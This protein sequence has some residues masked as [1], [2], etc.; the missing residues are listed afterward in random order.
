M[1]NPHLGQVAVDIDGKEYKL[2]F[3]S[4][5]LCELEDALDLNVVQISELLG[6]PKKSR[7]KNVRAMF[8]ASLLDH[9]PGTTM[10]DAKALMSKIKGNELVEM[11]GQAFMLAFPQKVE[12]DPAPADAASPPKPVEP[13]ADGTGSAS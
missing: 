5:A 8:W 3:S 10:D 2:S 12:G 1:A 6:D 4:N 9:Q 11:V 13:A 7:I